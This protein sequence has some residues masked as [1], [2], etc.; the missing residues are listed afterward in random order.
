MTIKSTASAYTHSLCSMHSTGKNES[1]PQRQPQKQ[2]P[3]QQHQQLIANRRML[4]SGFVQKLIYSKDLCSIRITTDRYNT[5]RTCSAKWTIT[6]WLPR[7][8]LVLAN[9]LSWKWNET[10]WIWNERKSSSNR[11]ENF[12]FQF[13]LKPIFPVRSLSILISRWLTRGR[14]PQFQ[15]NGIYY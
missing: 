5:Q 15:L 13:K 14:M 4:F 10:K 9:L 2:Q 1:A 12:L 8:E 7:L 6:N 11:S 3:Q